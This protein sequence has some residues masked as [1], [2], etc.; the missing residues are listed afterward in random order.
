M[1]RKRSNELAS[2]NGAIFK[3]KLKIKDCDTK[4]LKTI[5]DQIS[6]IITVSYIILFFNPFY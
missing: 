1:P 2:A 6:I 4:A 3:Y 5:Y